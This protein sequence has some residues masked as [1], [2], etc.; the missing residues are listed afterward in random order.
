[1][2]TL[3]GEARGL[4]Q[5]RDSD[6]TVEVIPIRLGENGGYRPLTAEAADIEWSPD[7]APPREAAR[8]LAAATVRLPAFLTRF[9]S[10]LDQ[11]LDELEWVTPL[12]WQDSDLLRGQLALP[13][14]HEGTRIVAGRTLRYDEELGLRDVT[15]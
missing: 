7:A 11:V 13:L 4:A 6:P 8:E 9:E 10:R 12:G 2:D 5:V 3:P 14:D 1:M 15:P